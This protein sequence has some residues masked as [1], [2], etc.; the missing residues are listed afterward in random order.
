MFLNPCQTP[1]GYNYGF[2]S[3]SS[4]PL[5]MMYLALCYHYPVSANMALWQ[6][7]KQCLIILPK[8]LTLLRITLIKK[9]IWAYYMHFNM[10]WSLPMRNSIGILMG[11]VL[12][13]QISSGV[14]DSFTMLFFQPSGHERFVYLPCLPYSLSFL[15][16]LKLSLKGSF[17]SLY[18][19][20]YF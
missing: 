4:L 1:G 16:V 9:R 2:I 17:I 3:L 7:F 5:S 12:N 6:K 15:S 20:L 14:K 10:V 8:L 18:R 19:L 13:M 11:I